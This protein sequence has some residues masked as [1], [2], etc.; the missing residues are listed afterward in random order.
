[1]DET[2]KTDDASVSV[3]LKFLPHYSMPYQLSITKHLHF[4]PQA[5][6]A[7]LVLLSFL[8]LGSILEG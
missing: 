3:K 1:M 7:V 8:V 6:I 5:S 4:T 2:E